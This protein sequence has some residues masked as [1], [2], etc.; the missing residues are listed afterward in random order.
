MRR[1]L[2]RLLGV[3][4]VAV[5]ALVTTAALAPGASARAAATVAPMTAQSWHSAIA[6]VSTP[7]KGCYTATYPA[8]TW[9]SVSCAAAPKKTYAP[10]S[11]AAS[12]AGVGTVGLAPE[13]VGNGVDFSA[14]VTGLMTGATGSFPTVT[15]VTGETSLGVANSYSLQLNS[16]PFPTPV[17]ATGGPSCQGWEQFILSNPG[18]TTGYVF[19]QFWLINYLTST[20][21][22]CPTGW[23]WAPGSAHCYKNGSA[24]GGIPS[25]PITTLGNLSLTGTVTGGASGWDTAQL[26]IAGSTTVY[27]ASTSDTTLDLSG[28]WTAAEFMIGGDGNSSQAAFNP[29]S[30]ITVQTVVHN[31]TTAAPTCIYGGWTGETN[32]LTLVGT[33]TY[34]TGASPSIR[35]VQSNI[36]GLPAS[37]KSASGTGEPHDTTFDGLYYDFQDQGTF[38]DT[39]TSTMTVQAEHIPA[40]PTYP[41]RT[42]AGAVGT[43]MGSD[44]VA[45][46]G[47]TNTSLYI[48]GAL[49]TLASGSAMALPSGDTVTRT[50]NT[51]LVTDPQGDYLQADTSS[52]I[53]MDLHVGLGTY[54]E[55]VGGLLANAPGNPGAFETS[56]GVIIPAPI[57]AS[58]T[59]TM[60]HVYGD[61]WRVPTAKS[62]VAVCKIQTAET[63]PTTTGWANT[64]PQ[65]VQAKALTV[66]QQDG[67]KDVTLLEAC[68]LDVAVLGTPLAARSFIGEPAPVVVGWS[69]DTVAK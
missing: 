28:G 48:D 32:N 27:S 67:V 47:V 16:R 45:L 14:G 29:G 10:Q 33:A 68:T 26:N 12:T 2:R 11:G 34:A 53:W 1:R 37:C 63:D 3:A 36:P 7:A 20:V 49:T 8:L 4:V 65:D 46:C 62:L 5:T 39:K 54:P 60:Y 18:S 40:P 30:T 57:S 23:T 43:Q 9:H 51:W 13:T 41:N 19:I 22:S 35:S 58:D 42:M 64:L 52:S 21:T 15:G 69:E 25:Q 59:T 56:T 17:C 38:T 24:I 44:T 55:A 61:S 6:H 31:G 50:G 66:C